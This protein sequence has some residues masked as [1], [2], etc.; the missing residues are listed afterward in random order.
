MADLSLIKKYI[1][2][3]LQEMAVKF[4]IP[5][6]FVIDMPDLIEMILG[7]KSIETNEDKQNWFNLLPL[8]NSEQLKKLNDILIKEKVKLK[9]IEDKY[10]AKKTEVKKKYLERW[11]QMWY[12]K[13][14]TEIKEKEWAEK[15]QEDK[16]A[17]ELLSKI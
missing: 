17:E 6:D 1:S 11:Q 15:S 7:S 2:P 9:E 3:K 14:V 5:D 12:V 8:M 16:E 4:D 10:E 13:K